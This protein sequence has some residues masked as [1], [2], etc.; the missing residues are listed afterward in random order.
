[1]MDHFNTVFVLLMI[2]FP[3][4]FTLFIG[5]KETG[6]GPQ[7]EETNANLAARQRRLWLWTT[8]AVVVYAG[9]RFNGVQTASYMLWIVCF[10]LWFF[11]A[12]PVV[13]AKDPGWRGAQQTQVRT[14]TLTRRDELPAGLQRAWLLLALLW[15]VLLI[16]AVAGIL[17]DAPG[18]EL[19][20]LL[21]FPLVSG[22][23]MALFYWAQGRSLIEPEPSTERETSELRLAREG[24]RNLK[25]YAWL[26]LAAVCVVLFSLPALTLIWFGQ[27]AM[28]VAIVIGAGGGALG[29][30][31]GGVFGTMVDLRRAKLNR[32][33]LEES[34]VS[35]TP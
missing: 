17:L 11:L 2:L 29:G 4:V 3:A 25:L 16:A 24:L 8:T 35:P 28:T 19:W 9:L 7:I 12:L 31:G 5:R 6:Q 1:M 32:L 13:Q 14:A 18:A 22:G 23:Q 26:G 33:C 10:P 30:I 34:T 27:P 15:S 20:W 21:I